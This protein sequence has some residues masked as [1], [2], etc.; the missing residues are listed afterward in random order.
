MRVSSIRAVYLGIVAP[1]P[2]FTYESQV[3]CGWVLCSEG[4]WQG[5]GRA[6]LRPCRSNPA[7]TRTRTRTGAIMSNEPVPPAGFTLIR[8]DKARRVY[9]RSW[10]AGDGLSCAYAKG[11]PRDLPCGP[12]VAVVIYEDA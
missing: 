8:N 7:P 3:S 1:T 6:G 11:A 10:A 12:P 4:L 9:A 2:S 5:C